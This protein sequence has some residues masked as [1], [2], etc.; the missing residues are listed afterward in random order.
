M[1][2]YFC[3]DDVKER[4]GY[5]KRAKGHNKKGFAKIYKDRFPNLPNLSA[6]Y[7]VSTNDEERMCTLF[8]N[9]FNTEIDIVLQSPHHLFVGEAKHE[10]DLKGRGNYVLVHQLI[11]EYVMATILVDLTEGDKDKKRKVVPFIVGESGKLGSL[12]NTV[13]VKFMVKQ[14]WLKEQHILSWDC[15]KDLANENSNPGACSVRSLGRLDDVAHL[16][17][18]AFLGYDPDGW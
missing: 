12:K 16:S 8:S 11:R 4:K 6:N 3:P 5:Y 10:S 15:I 14:G 18:A 2:D 13:Q 9:L 1:R 7:A 17:G